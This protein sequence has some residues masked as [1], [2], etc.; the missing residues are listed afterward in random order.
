MYIFIYLTVFLV[1]V[2]YNRFNNMGKKMKKQLQ[3]A[4]GVEEEVEQV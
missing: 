1:Y 2:I 3:E 4:A